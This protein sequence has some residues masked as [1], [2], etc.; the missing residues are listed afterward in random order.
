MT[1][2]AVARASGLE[3]GYVAGVER[4]ERLISFTKLFQ[5]AAVFGVPPSELVRLTE[6]DV[7]E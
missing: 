2:E 3:P 4:G 7:L 5:I 1:V 6:E